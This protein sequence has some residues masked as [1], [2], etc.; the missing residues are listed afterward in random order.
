M[1]PPLQIDDDVKEAAKQFA[2]CY[3]IGIPNERNFTY[4]EKVQL[5]ENIQATLSAR[6]ADLK[7]QL[8]LA[9]DAAA[10][11]EAGRNM[12]TALEECLKVNLEMNERIQ[13]QD[14]LMGKVSQKLDLAEQQLLSQA[15]TIERM[16]GALSFSSNK[17]AEIGMGLASRGLPVKSTADIIFECDK[18]LTAPPSD[19]LRWVIQNLKDIELETGCYI[20]GAPD[21][22]EAS[23]LANIINLYAQNALKLLS[24]ETEAK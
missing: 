21:A 20:D 2:D 3:I 19:T 13:K 6:L 1:T 17:A 14:V 11:G 18:A 24:P 10:K 5:F 9:N 7:Q 16:R 4:Y 12:G 23:K 8:L 15:L 22:S